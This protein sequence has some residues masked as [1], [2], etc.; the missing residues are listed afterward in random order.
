MAIRW[1]LLITACMSCLGCRATVP[2]G[3]E[4]S[5]EL[6]NDPSVTDMLPPAINQIAESSK[7]RVIVYYFHPTF[8]CTACTFAESLVHQVIEQRWADA[9][10]QGLL[11]W[12][13]ANFELAENR[14]LAKLYEIDAS[15]VVIASI[16]QG[17]IV[18]WDKIS[19]IWEQEKQPETFQD[20]IDDQILVFMRDSEYRSRS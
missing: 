2:K 3:A 6:A 14:P 17:K 9:V 1:F 11:Q 8:R 4:G 12:G 16:Y 15:A 10:A 20:L 18:K 13:P 7:L 19:K 5:A